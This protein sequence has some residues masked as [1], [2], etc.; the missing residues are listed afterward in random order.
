MHKRTL[1]AASGRKYE[2]MVR[3][4]FPVAACAGGWGFI[5]SSPPWAVSSAEIRAT[6]ACVDGVVGGWMEGLMRC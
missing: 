6:A 3:P 1:A 2:S 4:P 5:S